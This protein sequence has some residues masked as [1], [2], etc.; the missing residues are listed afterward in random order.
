MIARKTLCM[1]TTIVRRISWV[2]TIM[3]ASVVIGKSSVA[4]WP[5]HRGN[6]QRTGFR[7][8]AINAT[9]WHPAWSLT[10]ISAPNPAWPAPARGSL[11][12]NLDYIEARVTDDQA[13]VPLIVTDQN[14][15]THILVASSANDRLISIDPT[16]GQTQWQYFT[17]G[18]IRYAPSV[19]DGIAYLGADDGIVRAISITDGKE[20]W[21]SRIGPEM[22]LVVGNY[23][24]IS[25]HPV[26][27]SVLIDD[28]LVFASAGLFPSQGVYSVA[29]DKKD[30]SVVWRRKIAKSP[31][32]YL[33]ADKEKIFVPTGRT[34]PF[35]VNKIS[36]AY[37]HDLPS[38]G[39]SFCM[40]TPET[41]FTG[42]GNDSTIQTSAASSGA[43]MLSFKGKQLVAGGGKIW[44]TNGVKLVG[45]NLDAVMSGKDSPIWSVDC[46]LDQSL[47]V[48][49]SANQSRLFVAGKNLVQI[50]D[51]NNGNLLSTLRTAKDED[52]IKYLAVSNIE[53]SENDVLVASTR[54]GKIYCWSGSDK[55]RSQKWRKEIK[56]SDTKSLS[57]ADAKKSIRQINRMLK[58]PKG[59]A[60]VIGDDSGAYAETLASE[61]QLQIVSMISDEQAASA[62]QAEFQNKH[63]YGHRVSVWHDGTQESIQFSPGIFDLVLQVGTTSRSKNELLSLAA[64]SI[65]VV[66]LTA[67]E[68]PN[69]AQPVKNGGKWRHQYANP[70]NLSDSGDQVVGKAKA[71]RLQW[72]GGVGPSRMPDRHLRG[73]A[74]LAVGGAAVM[75]GDGVFIG[76]NPANGTERWQLPMPEGT[77]RYVTPFD[78]GY[79][80]LTDD[81]EKLFAAAG[82]ELWQINAYTGEIDQRIRVKP[83]S[84][85][86]GYV[87]ELNGSVFATL[88]KPT[89]PRTAKDK[90]TRYTYVNNDY[91]SDRPLVC[92]RQFEKMSHAGKRDWV[93]KSSGL[94]IH[95][96]ISISDEH[97]LF[98]EGRSNACVTHETDRVE[99]KLLMQDAHVVC[100]SNKTGKPV[101]EKSLNW[102]KASNMLFTQ[103]V[104]GK[105]TLTSSIS[106]KDKARYLVRV[107]ND[108]DGSLI[109]ETDHLHIKGGLFHGEQVHHPVVLKRT[110]GKK[111]LIAEPYIYDL[112]TGEKIVPEGSDPKWALNRPGHSCGT[113]TGAGDC[114]F[115]RASNPTVLN[116]SNSSFTALAPTRAGCWINMIPAGG[117]LLIPEASASCVCNYSLQTSMGFAPVSDNVEKAIPTLPDIFPA[118]EKG[119]PEELYSWSFEKDQSEGQSVKPAKG[120]IVLRSAK[121][122]RF[123]EHGLVLDNE[124]WLSIDIEKP[125]L[126]KMPA[127]ITLAAD[128][129]VEDCPDWCG[130]VGGLQDNGN[131]ERGALLGI[132]QNKY[133]LAIAADQKM[134]LTYMHAPAELEKNK[135]T[136]VV[137]TYDG[138]T[139]KLYVDGKMVAES[140][141]QS[142]AIVFDPNSWLAAGA[143]K[144]DNE[145]YLF[146]GALKSVS[147]FRGSISPN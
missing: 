62:L 50:F 15:T 38:P 133:F 113:L 30:G 129:F 19:K 70:S 60:L 112:E 72:F 121:P 116:L 48:S 118:L 40:L 75:Q 26:R 90:K 45:H 124:Q 69:Y 94:I 79:A 64:P 96:S 22:P 144:D 127:T 130:L 4:D 97:V 89:A 12:Q 25:P 126:P 115:F 142:G 135:L 125:G 6:S 108:N 102:A 107:L 82:Y 21:Q 11:W 132:H 123:N 49:G 131:Y 101:W 100:L 18:P 67:Q 122:M 103:L 61:T 139:M 104:D 47:M 87:T 74:P 42:P 14:G 136:R 24:V 27:T 8:Q 56:A 117:R 41:F 63:L 57:D 13:D 53:G 10:S 105:V 65:G 3:L 2:A 20:I 46:Q 1:E 55:K 85:R 119:P 31:Q 99:M 16:T 91:N 9:H 109:W 86:W 146:K 93:Y 35:A 128:V 17:K 76:I 106:E 68:E 43:K 147:V 33:L 36:G 81:G 32:G 140:K 114:L 98:V 78:A 59:F 77:M 54:S 5:A 137:G 71:F 7:E 83:E 58:S 51:A 29:L 52:E 141:E 28:D 92:S 23:R 143:Y 84:A 37:L 73:P 39:G 111:V 120:D 34:Q 134:R 66:W 110:D 44:T 138:S 80:C 145:L 88:M 95:G